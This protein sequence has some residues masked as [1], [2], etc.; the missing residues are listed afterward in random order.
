MFRICKKERNISL[1]LFGISG[2][3]I[4]MND[5]K[6]IVINKPK[7]KMCD[8]CGNE[9]S[10]YSFS[11]HIKHIHKLTSD[12]YAVKYSEFR[13]PKREKSTRNI[14]QLTCQLC[15]TLTPSVGM[16]THLRDSHNMIVDDYTK[17]FG[18]YRPS[19][20]RQ[21]EYVTRLD[22]IKEEDKEVCVICNAEFA[23]GILLGYH[24]K[25]IH[26]LTKRDYI[27]KHVFKETR[28]LCKCGC[29]KEVKL[30]NYYPYK[31]DYISGHNKPTLGFKFSDE[32]KI[33]MSLSAIDR[34]NTQTFKKTDTKPELEFK[35]ILDIL[36]IKYEHP[37]TVNLGKR[38]ASVDFY[39]SDY[40][41]LVE[42]DGEYWH[43]QELK[44]LNFHILPNVIS[45]GDR[46]GLQN[47]YRIREFDIDKFKNYATTKELAIEYL[48]NSIGIFNPELKYKQVIISKEYF[49]MCLDTKGAKYLK[50][51]NWLL[52]K[53]IRTFVPVLPYP[54]LEE[55]LL[56]VM[57]K[58]S[59]MDIGKAYNKETREF[60]NNISTVGHNYLKH[61]FKSY[62]KSK[63]NGNPSPVEA[64]L[65]DKIMQ[66]V[67]DYRVGCNNSGEIF[68]F[69]LHQLIRG[70]S[71][72][73]ITVSFFKPLLAAAIYRHYLGNNSVPV[74]LDPCS[75]FGG[76]LLGFK[77][78]Y[79]MGKYIGCE[80]N[81]DTY[82]ELIKLKENGKWEDTVEIYNCK[83]EDFINYNNYKFDLIF[84]SIPYYDI[85]IYSNNTEYKS[86]DEWQNTFIKSIERYSK[87][88]CYINVPAELCNRL[89]WKDIDSYISS[90]RSHFDKK[91]GKKLDPI[92]KL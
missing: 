31:V 47:L 69:S 39:L 72:R 28:P 58:L 76:R 40:D 48:K 88:N 6:R 2:I 78:I 66:E 37:Y 67:I 8:I 7:N 30:L 74:V 71:A 63:F 44:E 70:L 68:D 1:T 89:G 92:I 73:R 24:I 21:L 53:F 60:S 17:Q 65:D 61:H 62:W 34:I 41:M 10:L 15:N 86:F 36:Q 29:Q 26:N 3:V 20:L 35:V 90:N 12:E 45:D 33:K 55:N 84:T 80:P 85:E 4:G 83:F 56:G 14:K 46:R 16:F 57:D 25:N 64:W 11:G 49:K 18:E 13:Q 42:V 77:G 81:M 38:Y 54:D 23:S 82:N 50:S 32:S 19:K 9:F 79:P 75:G 22:T 5:K 59:T 43:P 91:V 52:K 51:Y 27:F 87:N